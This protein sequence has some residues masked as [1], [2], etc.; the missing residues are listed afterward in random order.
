MGSTSAA[1]VA[2]VTLV[3]AATGSFIGV[4]ICRVPAGRS[5]GG[6]S[7]CVCGRQLRAWENVPVLAWLALRGKARCC[8]AP[9][10]AWMWGLEVAAAVVGFATSTTFGLVGGIAGVAT[11]CT[12]AALIGIR[13][14]GSTG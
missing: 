10:P 9:I 8:G 3:G 7:T 6:R 13:R 4:V 11:F 14:R 5:I 1:L 2:Y 12:V